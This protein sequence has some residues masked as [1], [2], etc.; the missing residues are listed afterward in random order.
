MDYLKDLPLKINNV[1]FPFTKTLQI[2][3][4]TISNENTSETGKDIVQIARKD[5]R[6]FTIGTTLTGEWVDTVQALY[7]ED[8]VTVY[9]Y[10]RG[11]HA[12]KTYRCQLTDPSYKLH[13]NSEDLEGLDGVWDI[14]FK[15]KEL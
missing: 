3:P 2:T 4:K 1:V 13:K 14:S 8:E 9:M 6:E 5:K 11:T 12:Y 15:L 10:D 7:L